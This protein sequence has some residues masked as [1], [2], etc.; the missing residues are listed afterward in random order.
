MS[1]LYRSMAIS[2]G[3]MVFSDCPWMKYAFQELGEKESPANDNK[4]DNPRVSEYTKTVTKSN[5]KYV[6]IEWCSAFVSW[7]LLQANYGRTEAEIKKSGYSAAGAKSW[8]TWGIPLSKH[9]RFGAIAILTR[10]GGSG[11]VGF[12]IGDYNKDQILI[13]GGN[14]NN[15]V[16]IS[17]K[18]KKRLL[19]YVFPA[20]EKPE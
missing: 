20:V 14:Q 3:N 4:T 16:N 9:P 5:P 17:P 12:Y 18:E 13:L 8:L 1:V 2:L 15:E 11:H 6:E 19:N 10:K 7:C